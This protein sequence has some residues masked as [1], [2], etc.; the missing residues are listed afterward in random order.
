MCLIIASPMN[1]RI[2]NDIIED[3]ANTNSHGGGVAWLDQSTKTIKWKKG[4]KKDEVLAILDGPAKA[5]PH[6]VHFRIATHGGV[7]DGL[8]HPFS[9]DERASVETEGEADSVLFHNGTVSSWKEL[10]FNACIAG[11]QKVPPPPW[12]DTRAMA[13][14]CHVYGPHILSLVETGSRFLVFNAKVDPKERMLCWGSWH[15]YQRFRFSNQGTRAFHRPV[16]NTSR[17]A[18]TTHRSNFE[19]VNDR[20]TAVPFAER[21]STGRKFKPPANYEVWKKLTNDGLSLVAANEEAD[22]QLVTPVGAAAGGD[23]NQNGS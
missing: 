2:S 7:Q 13:I 17:S 4:L 22:N 14:L 6:V 1:D 23:S 16:E 19:P 5:T 9:I 8:C 10:L 12:S 11:G 15:D 18:I 20:R 3:A 21:S